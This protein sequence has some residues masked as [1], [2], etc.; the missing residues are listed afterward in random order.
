MDF[1]IGH[2]RRRSRG[3]GPLPRLLQLLVPLRVV[4]KAEHVDRGSARWPG[5]AGLRVYAC[6][7]NAEV[8]TLP[9]GQPLIGR[10]W[11]P[12]GGRGRYPDPRRGC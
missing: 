8:V 1:S 10:S 12:S 4:S 2:G 3:I 5:A 6:V 7:C 9:E 11:Q